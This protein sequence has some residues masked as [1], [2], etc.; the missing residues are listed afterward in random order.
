MLFVGY[1]GAG[2]VGRQ[3]QDGAS[4]V[5]IMDE[6]VQVRAEISTISGY[7]SHKDSDHLVDFVHDCNSKHLK[8]V[9]V[10]MGED[11]SSLF[12]VQKLRD[13]LGV[14]AFH[15]EAGESAQLE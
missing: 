6:E 2:T 12:L 14:K 9:F 11:K 7:S 3:I 8:K 1:Q 10:V 4:K 5:T 13:E 15:P